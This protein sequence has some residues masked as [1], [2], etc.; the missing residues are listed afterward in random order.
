MRSGYGL[1]SQLQMEALLGQTILPK[2][3]NYQE[4]QFP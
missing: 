2:F 4:G 1:V 3:L